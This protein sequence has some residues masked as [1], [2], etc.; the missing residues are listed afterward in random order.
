MCIKND[1]LWTIYTQLYSSL[2]T[3][4]TE[5]FY[6]A[7]IP[8]SQIH[9]WNFCMEDSIFG[10]CK[11]MVF[12][13]E[14][15]LELL[16]EDWLIGSNHL[17]LICI[18]L[19]IYYHQYFPIHNNDTSSFGVNFFF[20]TSWYSVHRNIKSQKDMILQHRHCWMQRKIFSP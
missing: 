4:C 2:G 16:R 1:W 8:L 9:Q 3:N 5:G 17:L 14:F 13:N 19:F 7:V 6:V 15:I 12:P 11:W 18:S 10:S 20:P